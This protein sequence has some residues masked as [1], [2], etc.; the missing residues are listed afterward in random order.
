MRHLCLPSSA[1]SMFNNFFGA[2]AATF[3]LTSNII[4]NMLILVSVRV[5]WYLLLLNSPS[6]TDPVH[7]K[8]A[9]YAIVVQL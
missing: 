2:I 4:P 1:M 3:F 5:G 8:L 9:N 6:V 7:N